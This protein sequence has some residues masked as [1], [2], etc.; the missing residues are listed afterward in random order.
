[1]LNVRETVI[2]SEKPGV[3]YKIVIVLGD[4]DCAQ[5]MLEDTDGERYG[6]VLEKT[7]TKMEK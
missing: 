4:G 1:M 6:Y 5:Y 2:C 3:I 7:L